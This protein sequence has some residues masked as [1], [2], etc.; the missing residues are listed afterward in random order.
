MK[1]GWAWVRDEEGL[2]GV[3]WDF[4]LDFF[5]WILKK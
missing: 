5:G 2:D 3:C 4:F 1:R